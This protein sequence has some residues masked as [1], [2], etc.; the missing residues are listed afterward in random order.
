MNLYVRYFDSEVL[1]T[2]ADDAISFLYGIDEIGM[3]DRIASDVRDYYASDNRFPKRYKVRPKVY[4]IMIKTDADT[5]QAFKDYRKKSVSQINE[6]GIQPVPFLSQGHQDYRHTGV[7]SIDTAI[8]S[9]QKEH[10][11]WYEGSL[12]FKRVVTNPSTGKSEYRDTRFVARC[13]AMSGME[14]YSRI[15]DHLYSRVD[16]RSQFP[17]AKGKNFRFKFLGECKPLPMDYNE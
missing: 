5:M 15:V 6:G 17:S 11:G 13:K 9:L 1:V 16:G 2:N 12:D 3:N 14:C 8:Y 4:F 10:F 7:H